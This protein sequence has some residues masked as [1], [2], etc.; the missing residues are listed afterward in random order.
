MRSKHFL[1]ATLSTALLAAGAA[2][3]AQSSD[4]RPRV[5]VDTSVGSFVIELDAVRAPLT[6][7]AFL[8]YVDQDFYSNTIVHRVAPGFIVQAGGYTADLA[9]KPAGE[10]VFNESGNGLTNLRGT[11][12]LARSNEPH[13]GKSEFY[14]NLVE[15]IDLNPR[16]TR[17]GYAVFGRVVEGMEVVDTIGDV[18]TTAAGPFDGNV[19]VETIVIESI[20]RLP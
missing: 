11:V 6:V 5:R 17:W 8:G 13:S 12:G 2:T 4:D 14:I 16:P 9:A 20:E 19:P 18:A 3:H 7:A 15:N 10:P 1:L